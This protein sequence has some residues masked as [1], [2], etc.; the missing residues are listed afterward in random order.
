MKVSSY[1]IHHTACNSTDGALEG[2]VVHEDSNRCPVS[3]ESEVHAVS[4]EIEELE[5][6]R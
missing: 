5:V 4:I 2:I 1:Q 6:S 3:S